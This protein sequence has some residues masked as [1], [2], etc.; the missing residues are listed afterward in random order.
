MNN[1]KINKKISNK[2]FLLKIISLFLIFLI[3]FMPF[4]FA[5]TI[6]SDSINAVDV[7]SDSA[8]I[9]WSTD[10]E[11]SGFLEYGI[12]TNNLITKPSLDGSSTNHHVNLESLNSGT[13]YYYKVKAEAP[14]NNPSEIGFFDFTTLLNAPE[15]LDYEKIEANKFKITWNSINKANFYEVYLDGNFYEKISS[16]EIILDN[17]EYDKNY[18]IKVLAI[19]ESD[20]KSS[21][22]NEL[23]F[24][25][26]LIPVEISFL[27]ATEISNTSALIRWE[28]T[29]EVESNLNYSQDMSFNRD[30]N[31]QAKKTEHSILLENLKPDTRYNYKVHADGIYSE[32]KFFKTDKNID[33][34]NV[35]ISNI[36]IEIISKSNAKISWNTNINANSRVSY[37]LTHN[38]DSDVYGDNLL[39]NHELILNDL[40]ENTKY[41]FKVISNNKESNYFSFTT[42]EGAV[43]EP[44]NEP[45]DDTNGDN[46]EKFLTLNSFEEVTNNINFNVSGKSLIGS[47]IYIF[48]NDLD[49][50][51]I[52]KVL[53]KTNFNY[54]VKLNSAV[55]NNGVRGRNLIKVVSWDN[56]NNK[57]EETIYVTLDIVPPKLQINDLPKLTNKNSIDIIGTGEI[58]ASVDFYLD[59]VSQHGINELTKENFN[60]SFNLGRTGEFKIKVVATDGASNENTFKHTI[61]V[62]REAP[63]IEFENE[64]TE[65]HFSIYRIVGKTKPNSKVTVINLAEYSSCDSVSVELGF[66]NCED[67]LN[68]DKI[69]MQVSPLAAALG[70]S[71]STK[72]DKNGD[73]EVAIPL[74]MTDTETSDVTGSINNLHIVVKDEAGN[75]RDYLKRLEYK[76]GCYEFKV[77][78]VETYPFNI[79]VDDMRSGE[80]QASAMFPIEYVGGGKAP[81]INSVTMFKDKAEIGSGVVGNIKDLKSSNE[82]IR[83]GNPKATNYD[84]SSNSL[85]VYAP[86]NINKYTGDIDELPDNLVAAL[87]INIVYDIPGQGAGE[88][89]LYPLISFDIQKPIDHSKWLSPKMINKTIK[90]LDDIIEFT[91][92]FRDVAK[93]ASTYGLLA[94]GALIA[95]NYISSFT[96]DKSQSVEG[97]C[98]QQERDMEKVYKMCDRVLCPV[99][100]PKCEDFSPFGQ[101]TAIHN[102]EEEILEEK[103]YQDQLKTNNKWREKY[104]E[105]VDDSRNKGQTV[106]PFDDWIKEKNIDGEGAYKTIIPPD[107]EVNLPSDDKTEITNVNLQFIAVDRNGRP[108]D[109]LPHESHV[110]SDGSEYNFYIDLD[111]AFDDALRRCPRGQESTLIIS[112]KDRVSRNEPGIFDSSYIE[113]VRASKCVGNSLDETL[114]DSEYAEDGKPKS[115]NIPGC[116]NAECPQFDNSK[117]PKGF[118]LFGGEQG[119]DNINPAGGLW[120]SLQCVCF[121]ALWK[122][123]ENYLKILTGAK[124]CL[125]QALIGETTAGFC[126]RLLAQFVCD[127]LVEALKYFMKA[128][129]TKSTRGVSERGLIDNY[130]DNSAQIQ[131]GLSDRYSGVVDER[132]GLST[133]QL[134]H[135]AC[136]A[137]ITQDWSMIEGVFDNYVEHFDVEPIVNIDAESRPYGYDPFT[138]EMSIGYNIYLGVVPGGDTK[139]EL[140]LECDPDF[141]GG[142]YCAPDVANEQITTRQLTFNSPALN[143]NLLHIDNSALFWYNKVSVR[144]S[145]S[146]GGEQKT[147][148]ITKKIWKKGDLAFNCH[149]SLTD[150]IQCPT[151]VNFNNRKG[152]VELKPFGGGTTLMPSK[153]YIY[154]KDNLIFVFAEIRNQFDEDF[155][156]HIN[157]NND[158]FQYQIPA[159]E[160]VHASKDFGGNRL[161]LLVDKIGNQ[162]LQLTEDE[163]SQVKTINDGINFQFDEQK[164]RVSNVES[165][166]IKF[167]CDGSN[168]NIEI[169]ESNKNDEIEVEKCNEKKITKIEAWNIKPTDKD[170]KANINFFI[171]GD[172]TIP[173]KIY[174][175]ET[176]E[177]TRA[178]SSESRRMEI[179]V[180]SDSGSGGGDTPILYDTG[181]SQK[182]NTEYRVFTGSADKNLNQKPVVQIIQPTG[183]HFPKEGVFPLGFIAIDDN[184]DIETIKIKVTGTGQNNKDIV[185]TFEI[186]NS[187]EIQQKQ[188]SDFTVEFSGRSTNLDNYYELYLSLEERDLKYLDEDAMYQV[189]I[190][191]IEK[192]NEGDDK[193]TSD[194][195]TKTFRIY[196]DDEIKK[197]DFLIYLGYPD[198]NCFKCT[199][200]RNAPAHIEEQEDTR[201]PTT[202][203]RN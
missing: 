180:L 49:E 168:Q 22:S 59:N 196:Q 89:E 64:F 101:F 74:L 48:V 56:E 76:P 12:S 16:N 85:F 24:K 182:T 166:A 91:E 44:E 60:H 200:Q 181:K 94:C 148:T 47:K 108:K 202:R 51:Q 116:Y 162:G 99:A 195:E 39:K 133:D 21:F 145:Y 191:A 175:P 83:I 106:K 46:G 151:N 71:Q 15:N 130:K 119:Y 201:L 186:I 41:Y 97:G 165:G 25:T 124:K 57:N 136:V 27:Q 102:G 174:E 42:D 11:S 52:Q 156:I 190:T 87:G 58:G 104:N 128:L 120:S 79:Y 61:T 146:V 126:E 100:P 155:Y 13:K 8:K 90:A 10:I 184:N 69:S 70:V 82:L 84:S 67:Y 192:E 125:E 167:F 80:I 6:N 65:T 149:F 112:R 66:T 77:G 176:D 160:N 185:C 169:E 147:N 172:K 18:K 189:R 50:P 129:E 183:T 138:G 103:E 170:K 17:L 159:S 115:S 163:E 122:H 178:G 5:L 118:G 121:P 187:D 188:C 36:K 23:S 54:E 177:E 110:D 55:T 20:R 73:F 2:Q 141:E 171:E 173:I 78:N 142:E 30:V 29:R 193:L 1:K 63:E 9:M 96:K 34:E 111:R 140:F 62:D 153:T 161:L 197:E 199:Q 75:S 3:S 88:C 135:K 40:D 26:D 150:G 164:F 95:W 152:V 127:L 158:E 137:G 19:D 107:F 31:E 203:V 114:H 43:I 98:S 28:T 37:G 113:E 134:I 7:T 72:S 154:H 38:L 32:N 144:L 93:Q 131:E 143:E 92:D 139:L 179:D 198:A 4:T 14:D 117:C 109:S 81:V 157:A 123:L 53:E 45:S 132:M 86:I 194:P 35:I 68:S 33:G 105:Y